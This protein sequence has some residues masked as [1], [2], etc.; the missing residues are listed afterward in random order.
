MAKKTAKQIVE[1]LTE[2]NT[3]GVSNFNSLKTAVPLIVEAQKRTEFLQ[4]SAKEIKEAS[5][6]LSAM[7]SAYAVA[8]LDHVFDEIDR[9]PGG[10]VTG[11]ISID[12]RSYHFVDGFKG[13]ERT[14]DGAKFDQKYLATLAEQG[15]AKTKLE[16]DQTEIYRR[17]LSA[18]DTA[19]LGFARKPNRVWSENL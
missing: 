5:D 16:L 13:Y 15:L 12:G 19:A 17:K 7:T 6:E 8:H 14:E 18:E 3:A 11:D 10:T 4:S 9:Q 2:M 1:E